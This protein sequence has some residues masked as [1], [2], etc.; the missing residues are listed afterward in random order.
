MIKYNSLIN[1]QNG[2]RFAGPELLFSKKIIGSV[3]AVA[4]VRY[5]VS[6]EHPLGAFFLEHDL[7]RRS[8]AAGSATGLPAFDAAVTPFEFRDIIEA[9][10]ADNAVVV[11]TDPEIIDLAAIETKINGL[12]NIATITRGQQEELYFIELAARFNG[13]TRTYVITAGV[14]AIS[15]AVENIAKDFVS[16]SLFTHHR[17]T[18]G[19]L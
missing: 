5:K 19:T 18:A 16:Y 4:N 12:G 2:K 13:I 7:L 6:Q 10:R 1:V 17:L 14:I 15:D 8:V 11:A 9:Y 3:S